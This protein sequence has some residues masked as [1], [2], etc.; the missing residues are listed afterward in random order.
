MI[1][2]LGIEYLILIARGMFNVVASFGLPLCDHVLLALCIVPAGQVGSASTPLVQP[3]A[4]GS[5]TRS[6]MLT[7]AAKFNTALCFYFISWA[8]ISDI[9]SLGYV[10]G[11]FKRFFFFCN[12]AFGGWKGGLGNGWGGLGFLHFKNPV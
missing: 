5:D 7:I 11:V 8:G 4:R 2:R 9:D 12:L 1:W 6:S 3:D 10:N